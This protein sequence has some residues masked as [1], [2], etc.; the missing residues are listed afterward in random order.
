MAISFAINTANALL[1]QITSR[2]DLGTGAGNIVI[3]SG[4][5]PANANAS[6]SGNTVLATLVCSDPSAGAA[7]NKVLTLNSIAQ[8][9]SAD[10]TGEATFFRIMDSDSNVVLQGTVSAVG[11]GGDLTM[12]TTAIVALGPVSV[13][14][15]TFSLL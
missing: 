11:G 5:V 14:S 2:I 8:D 1:N 3:Y 12:N 10:A 15:C 9:A 13:T 4:T 7:T 6:L